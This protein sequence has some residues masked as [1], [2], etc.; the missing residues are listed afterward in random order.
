MRAAILVLLVGCSGT[1]DGPGPDVS[2]RTYHFGPYTLAPGQEMNGQCVSAT[3][4]NDEPLYVNS[5]E[6]TTGV[7]F[8]HSNWFWVPETRF[9]GPDGTWRCRDRD[10]D[11]AIAGIEGGV[12]FAQSTQAQHEI[13]QFEPGIAIVIPP[14][15]RIVA[16]T[17]LLN[18]SDEPREVPLA[19]TITPIAEPRIRLAG[20]AFQN[21]GIQLPPRRKS[22]FTIECPLDEAHRNVLSRPMDYNVH[23][24]LPHYHDLGTGITLDA[25]RADGSEV[26]LFE[27]ASH[28][29]DA[30]GRALSPAFSMSG[31]AKLRFSCNFDNPRD[32][33][34]GWGNGNGEMCIFL[35]FTDSTFN[36]TGGQLSFGPA[37]EEIDHGDVLERI[38]ACGVLMAEASI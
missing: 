11:E 12:L 15:S 35:A 28:V 3:L 32:T 37:L 14:R 25:I 38:H 21:Q 17:H 30:L 20:M 23:Y 36:V 31:F 27:N 10:F 5:V 24:V 26:R 1:G 9:G 34:V 2:P 8:H 18:P 16:G 6:L 22:R 7:G 29:G 13:Q 4:D 33:A 19:L